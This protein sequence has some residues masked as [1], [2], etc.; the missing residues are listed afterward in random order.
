MGARTALASKPDTAA[1][2]IRYQRDLVRTGN[3][4]PIGRMQKISIGPSA[5]WTPPPGDPYI[6]K[7]GR[8]IDLRKN[9]LPIAHSPDK[10]MILVPG[11][12]SDENGAARL[13]DVPDP[14][15]QAAPWTE[16]ESGNPSSRDIAKD[17][18]RM[19][20]QRLTDRC[21]QYL[22]K[23]AFVE[24]TSLLVFQ[25]VVRIAFQPEIEGRL[26]GTAWWL[27]CSADFEG[28]SAT[29]LI[30]HKTGEW[31]FL[32]GRYEISTP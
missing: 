20:P 16:E 32:Y 6:Q 1:D 21:D 2:L 30:D 18:Q 23:P 26:V 4:L 13:P 28:K 5:D 27:D 24:R 10:Q 19:I 12:L 14:T 3:H 15:W 7:F 8:M 11:V 17:T 25:P 29:L 9:M 22:G 31:F